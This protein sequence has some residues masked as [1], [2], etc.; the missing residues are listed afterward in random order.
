MTL[1][2]LLADDH[3]MFRSALR[4]VLGTQGD[5]ECVAE[6]ADGLVHEGYGTFEDAAIRWLNSKVAIRPTT[7][8]SYQQLL[9]CYRVLR[10]IG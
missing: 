2:I 1:R 9:S 3:A 4:A 7:R 8:R 10:F 6:V 5:F